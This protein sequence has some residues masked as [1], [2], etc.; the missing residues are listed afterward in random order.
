MSFRPICLALLLAICPLATSAMPTHQN[1]IDITE[2]DYPLLIG[3]WYWINPEHNDA[4]KVVKKDGYRA[5]N[6][7]FTSNYEFSIRLLHHDGEVDQWKG[8]YDIDD[9][10]LTFKAEDEPIQQHNYR[11]SYNQFLLD[12]ARFTKLAPDH[13]AGV[14]RSDSI[15]G[16]DV[17]PNLTSMS[18][19]L[20][21]DFLFSAEISGKEG[22]KKEHRGIYYLEDDNLVLI[23]EE[24]QHQSRFEVDPNTLTLTNQV[25][26]MKAI[27]KR[28]E[29]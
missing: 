14:W 28:A 4:N 16:R 1:E 3:N 23:Y 12:G 18:I 21:P 15:S 20:R 6:L 22:E 29:Q 9:T 8:E 13:L 27:M 11:L 26:G 17:D 7:T 25:F 5:M 10:S 19:L 24:G 2:F